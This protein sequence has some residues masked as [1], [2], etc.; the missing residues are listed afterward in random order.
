MGKK[1]VTVV[2]AC[3]NEEQNVVPLSAAI[4]NVF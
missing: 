3:Y 1:K 2:I 4:E